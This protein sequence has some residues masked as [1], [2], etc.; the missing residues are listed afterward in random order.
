[1]L[2]ML[3]AAALASP[4][5]V[6]VE[7][8]TSEGCSSCPSADAALQRIQAEAPPGSLVLALEEHVD[9]WDNLGWR[10]PYSSAFFTE[11][12]R[13]YAASLSRSRVYTPQM[14][15]DGAAEFVG[16]DE[17][18]AR[19][20][21]ALAARAKKPLVGL[22]QAGGLLKIQ[23]PPLEEAGELWLAVSES[24][25]QSKVE[26]GENEGKL[27]KHAPVARS[28]KRLG[29][30]PKAG[31]PVEA[32]VEAA[33]GRSLQAVVFVTSARTRKVLAAA[34]LALE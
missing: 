1:M 32:K 26:R 2:P 16:S 20:Q 28:L 31:A 27:L 5:P 24:G 4:T 6:L 17:G 23:P 13:G 25:L 22:S 18:E 7:L 12:Q 8:F 29:E 3:L 33:K 30:V 34:S 11:R 21:I 19:R 14:V 10:D 15:V 9:Y